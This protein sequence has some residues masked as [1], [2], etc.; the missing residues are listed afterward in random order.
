MRRDESNTS[1]PET[2]TALAQQRNLLAAFG[3]RQQ[4]GQ[5]RAPQGFGR[6]PGP[7][8]RPPTVSSGGRWA[9]PGPGP[10]HLRASALPAP[11]AP[12]RGHL[13]SCGEQRGL[14]YRPRDG[15]LLPC[16]SHPFPTLTTPPKKK[17]ACEKTRGYS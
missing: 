16:A 11:P 3:P 4:H 2:A 9:G 13:A 8:Q 5:S 14:L 10:G 15:C 17:C 7:A 6:C 12:S 1:G